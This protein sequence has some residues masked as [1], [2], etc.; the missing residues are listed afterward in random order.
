MATQA[1]MMMRRCA[2]QLM[3]SATAS[4]I[5]IPSASFHSS[6]TRLV[7][8]NE[9]GLFTCTLIPGDGVSIQYIKKYDFM[10]TVIEYELQK[11]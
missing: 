11:K 8:K 7:N 1:S 9:K 10:V 3:Q 4:N 5:L 2:S 6:H